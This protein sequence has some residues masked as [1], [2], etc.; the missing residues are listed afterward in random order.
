MYEPYSF[1]PAYGGMNNSISIS[2]DVRKQWSGITGSP[3]SQYLLAHMPLY[4]LSSGAG[5]MLNNEEIGASRQF[6]GQLS[7]NYVF[8]KLSFGLLSAGVSVGLLNRNIDGNEIRTPGGNYE[9][10][11]QHNDPLLFPGAGNYFGS[12]AGAG[13]FLRT[14]SLEIGLSYSQVISL[15]FSEKTLS[16]TPASHIILY[17]G[18]YYELNEDWKLVPSLLLKYNSA[19]LQS[20]VDLQVY[21]NNLIAGIGVRGYSSKSIDCIKINLG[22]RLSERLL[23][24]YNYEATLSGLKSYSDNTHELFI[25]YRI[26]SKLLKKPE[27]VIYHPRM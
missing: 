25:Q 19:I 8:S 10:S 24:A 2:G 20:D 27:N 5:I 12:T 3:S 14:T 26:P 11:V 23:I 4:H 21:R 16:Y 9:N 17:G 18:Y 7:Y 13:I 1:N 22:G 6:Q 15:P